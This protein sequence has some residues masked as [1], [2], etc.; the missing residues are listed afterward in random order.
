MTLIADRAATIAE[1]LAYLRDLMTT[2]A[3]RAPVTSVAV[4]GNAPLDPSDERADAM[5]GAD[6]VIRVN[7]FVLDLPGE[8]RAQGRRADVVLWNRITKP[9]RFTF[10]R[11]RERLYLLAEPM[12]AH[13]RREVW[14]MSWPEDLGFV[15][16]PNGEVL[17][18]IGEELE[19]PWL[20]EKLAPTT[21]FTAAWLMYSLFPEADLH[22]AGFSFVDAPDQTAWAYQAGGSS[23]VG[24]E[25]RINAEARLMRTWLK[26]DRVVLWR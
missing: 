6:L 4:L 9:T 7:G 23:P 14:P 25:H 18:R 2:Y 19:I 11:Y 13:G 17:S 21:G 26:E 24:P 16:L 15:P 3:K 12:R 10:D 8:P 1:G 20:E 22:L 5:D